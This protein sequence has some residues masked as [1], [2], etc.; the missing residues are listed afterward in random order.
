MKSHV[1]KLFLAAALAVPVPAFAEQI[2]ITVKGMVCSFCA[3]GIKKTFSRRKVVKSI[4]VDLDKKLV[5]IT[6]YDDGILRDEDIHRIIND[7]GYDVL[8]ISRTQET[9][10]LEQPAE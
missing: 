10:A 4:D 1:R 8:E 2:T 6:T 9:A 7:A 5:N 3:Q